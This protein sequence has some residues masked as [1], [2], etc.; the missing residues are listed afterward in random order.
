MME[1]AGGVEIQDI[2]DQT[3]SFLERIA[4]DRIDLCIGERQML[5]YAKRRH[6]LSPKLFQHLNEG[7]E[8]ERGRQGIK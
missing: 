8:R 2:V 5:S 4:F 7:G 3:M 1:A 6:W